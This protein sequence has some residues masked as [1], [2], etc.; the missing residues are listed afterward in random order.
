MTD[1]GESTRRSIFIRGPPLSLSLCMEHI[2]T[3]IHCNLCTEDRSTEDSL[4]VLLRVGRS[5]SKAD[6]LTVGLA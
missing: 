6:A 3:R 2:P 4:T 5:T 1:V